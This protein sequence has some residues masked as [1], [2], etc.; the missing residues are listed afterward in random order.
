MEEEEAKSGTAVQIKEAEVSQDNKT[1]WTNFDGFSY[2]DFG[3]TETLSHWQLP[4]LLEAA[5]YFALMKGLADFPSIINQIYGIFV[6]GVVYHIDTAFWR[7]P[8]NKN[9][10]FKIAQ[11]VDDIGKTSITLSGK[12]INKLDNK[13]L[14][15][16]NSKTVY[17]ERASG[18]PVSLPDWVAPKWSPSVTKKQFLQFSPQPSEVPEGAFQYNVTVA[19]S[20]T[21]VNKH[22]NQG[23]YVRFCC[24][25][26]QAAVLAQQLTGFKVDI[27][28]YPLK[29][30]EVVYVGQSNTGYKLNVWLWQENNHINLLR[31]VIRH[32]DGNNRPTI[33]YGFMEYGLMPL[34]SRL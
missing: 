20:D 4:K 22:T 14:V 23:S 25:A 19:A 31:F 24:D 34:S 3:R 10:P 15:T 2:N 6:Y 17:V 16:F 28:R 32:E 26:A 13:E 12:L 21:D 33:C 18:R 29:I 7:I 11:S 30:L 1:F 8:R 9:F 27:A 5:R